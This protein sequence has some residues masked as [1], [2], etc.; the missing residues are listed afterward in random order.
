MSFSPVFQHRVQTQTPE[1]AGAFT[2]IFP[3]HYEGV[4]ATT[5]S[6]IFQ[7]RLTRI[8]S[9]SFSAVFQH[10]AVINPLGRIRGNQLE[11]IVTLDRCVDLPEAGE[12]IAPTGKVRA[13]AEEGAPRWVNDQGTVFRLDLLVVPIGAVIAW[14]P[15]TANDTPP[16]NFEWCDGL[17]VSTPGS[18][19]FNRFKPSLMR[20]P[21]APGAVQSFI[22]GAD[23][24]SAYGG[25]NP[26]ITGGSDDHSHSGITSVDGLHAHTPGSIRLG[27]V[28]EPAHNH[29]GKTSGANTDNIGKDFVDN[30]ALADFDEHSHTISQDGAHDHGAKTSGNSLDSSGQTSNA[31][32]HDHAIASDAQNNDPIYVELAW[33]VRVL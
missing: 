8:N 7:H 28:N 6:A 21:D 24:D 22:R 13:F 3:H 33:I 23:A 12:T 2:P 11:P 29:T 4:A 25:A 16:E 15:E 26:L 18:P 17:P 27:I 32:A 10:S 19:L 31:S 9:S 20:S 14:W 30:A 1:E 5:F